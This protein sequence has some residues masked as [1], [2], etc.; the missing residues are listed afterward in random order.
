V[1]RLGTRPDPG[2]EELRDVEIGLGRGQAAERVGLAG[3]G[4]MRCGAVGVRVDRD[5][6]DPELPEGAEDPK[7]DL[8]PI[9]NKDFGEHRPYSPCG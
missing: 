5:R 9:G 1:H 7:R 4:H 3:V 8:A 2:L 6:A